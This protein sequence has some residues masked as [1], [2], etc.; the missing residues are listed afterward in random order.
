MHDANNLSVPA[1]SQTASQRDP[2]ATSPLKAAALPQ[3]GAAVSAPSVD[4]AHR[5]GG[6]WW[7]Q[8]AGPVRRNVANLA[9]QREISSLHGRQSEGHDHV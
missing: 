8:A 5:R 3:R 1:A 7:R 4:R 2:E 6:E 9:R